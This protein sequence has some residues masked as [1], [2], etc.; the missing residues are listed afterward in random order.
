M[1]FPY[2]NDELDILTLVGD[3]Y[4]GIFD[5][6]S[7]H[8]FEA[9]RLIDDL[10]DL[11]IKHDFY[12][13]ILQ[14][15]F[16]HDRR[17]SR[18]FEFR[19]RK[20]PQ[21]NGFDR[22]K[23]FD[24]IDVE[25]LKPLDVNILYK[26]DDLPHKDAFG[27]AT[28]LVEELG[29]D[30]DVFLN[31]G[32]FEHLLPIGIPYKLPN[33][34]KASEVAKLVKGVTLNGHVHTASVFGKV[35][36]HGSFDRLSHGEEEAK[37]FFY[38]KYDTE[39]KKAKHEFIENKYATVFH[40]INITDKEHDIARCKEYADERVNNARINSSATSPDMFIRIVSESLEA[41]QAI[42]A[43]I[44]K[45]HSD[46]ILSIKHVGQD[47]KENDD[48]MQIDESLEELNEITP[49]NLPD[50]VGKFVADNDT[51]LDQKYIDRMLKLS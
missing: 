20:V 29:V 10:I 15:T 51:P 8:S 24:Q 36:N 9:I 18:F 42:A 45:N 27:K 39:T 40:T 16:T 4:D 19:T 1:I 12:I 38:I 25:C 44:S 22:I 35:I 49:L 32:Y 30:I 37:G 6:G 31:H 43:H 7:A 26:P 14:G 2:L 5:L 41:R 21:L 33:T 11:S 23:F 28:K 47:T 13:R 48:P 34:L 3:F 46:V 50:M 17:Q